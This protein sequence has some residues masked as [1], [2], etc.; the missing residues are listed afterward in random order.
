MRS[1]HNILLIG[2]LLF[3]TYV[4]YQYMIIQPNKADFLPMNQQQFIQTS[5]KYDQLPLHSIVYQLNGRKP[6][7]EASD[8]LW[9]IAKKIYGTTYWHENVNPE[10]IAR[11][12][13]IESR[14]DSLAISSVGAIGLGQIRPE[15]WLHVFPECGDDLKRVRDNVCFTVKI[16]KHYQNVASSLHEA[17]LLYNGCK[18]SHC[19]WYP[20]A[21]TKLTDE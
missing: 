13:Y 11:L 20:N 3:F 9:Y 7:G 12:I 14:S 6:I 19:Y 16:F 8:D 1:A 21:V 4:L 2:I 17:L 18:S 10:L 5:L 15:I